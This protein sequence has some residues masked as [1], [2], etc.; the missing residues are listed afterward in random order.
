MANRTVYRKN[1]ISYEDYVEGSTVRKKSVTEVPQRTERTYVDN[2]RVTTSRSI[3]RNREKAL[4]MSAPYVIV[5]ALC[6]IMMCTV[7][8]KYLS[9]RDEITTKSEMIAQLEVQTET[10]K[11]HNDNLNYSINSY[12]DIEYISKVATE[13]LGMIK[14]GKD[15]I[16]FYESSESEYMKQF[17]DIPAK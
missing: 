14:A 11:S 13:E 1:Y 10:L 17:K 3:Y 5:L 2:E 12:M 6:S 15:Q 8:A 4:H 7:C 9:L 16:L